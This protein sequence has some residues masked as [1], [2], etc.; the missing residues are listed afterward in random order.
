MKK[1]LIPFASLILFAAC[2]K[3]DNSTNGGLPAGKIAPDGFTY[4]TTKQIT[5]DVTLLTNT[6][7]ALANIPVAIYTYADGVRG[8]KIGTAITDASGKINFTTSVA[9]EIDTF[10]VTPNFVGV[11]NNAKVF[12]ANNTI[13]CT[14][15]GSAGFKGNVVGTFDAVLKGSYEHNAIGKHG[16]YSTFDINGT[17][18]ST[19]FS[20]LDTTDIQG[21]PLHRLMSPNDVIT[22]DLLNNITY[23]L[24]EGVN[25]ST[26]TRGASY[27]ASNATS[28]I[29]M[30][31]DGDVTLTFAYEG[32]GYRSGLGY[33]TYPTST[34]PTTLADIKEIKFIF[35]NCSLNGSGGSLISGNKVD[36]GT[37][38]AG[39]TIGFVLYANGFTGT[40]GTNNVNTSATAFFTDSYLNPE[41]ATAKQ[42]HTVLLN[43]TDPTTK[44]PLFLVG[45]E[46]INREVGGDNDFNDVVFYTTCSTANAIV[47]KGVAPVDV[48]KDTDGDGV[49]DVLDAYPN[50]ATRA[51]DNY[52]PSASQYGTIAFEDNW[53]LQGDYDM[54]D[55]V[56]SYQY[57]LVSNAKNQVVEIFGD[58]A[59]IAAGANYEN[60][61]GIQFPFVSGAV[62]TV[63]GQKLANGYIKQN[64]NNTEAS[65]TNA[66]VIPFDGTKQLIS[67]PD[68]AAF[69]NTD[70]SRAKVKGD[71]SH[72]YVKLTTL[73]SNLDPATF[74]PFL[75]SNKRRG[76]EIHLPGFVPTNLADKT[77]FG[78]GNDASNATTGIYYVTKNNYPFAINFPTTFTY[79]TETTPINNAYPHFFDWTGANGKS[80]LDWYSN[81]AT[82][83]RNTSSLYTK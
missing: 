73:Q 50:D 27:L 83:Y 52:Y 64:S 30:Q 61:F 81:T 21:K 46:D 28:D 60:G 18:T 67:N 51:Y 33:Y 63:T 47:T 6:D 7:Q 14:L 68:G 70:P 55:L 26:S 53:P 82:G 48:P 29:V 59:P 42:K 77:L 75:I 74:N 54:N 19:V 78:T 12:L 5:A 58:F 24:P 56:V 69:I 43:Y 44:N 34:P 35:P 17:K 41:K 36:L 23:S 16:G 22:A 65:Q 4:K 11:I 15:G 71:T 3:T 66:V 31:A 62:N 9:A 10:I 1:L 13:S 40:A 20:Y 80:Y 37:F 72:V 79:P 57:K 45:F 76:Y 49:N 32:A 38:K 25:L 2:K 39:T 8:N